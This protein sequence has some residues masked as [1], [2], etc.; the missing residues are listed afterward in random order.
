VEQSGC[1]ID[2]KRG[3]AQG[4]EWI[5]CKKHPMAAISEG[6]TWGEAAQIMGLMG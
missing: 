6:Y 1:A 5:N 3:S 2:E 4:T